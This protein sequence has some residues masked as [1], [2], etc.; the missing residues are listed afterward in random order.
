MASSCAREQVIAARRRFGPHLAPH[1]LRVSLQLGLLHPLVFQLQRVA[2]LLRLELLG[3]QAFHAAL[4]VGRQVH[5]ADQHALEQHAVGG[6]A[7][8]QLGLQ[9]LLD[10][11]AL[12]GEDLAHRVAREHLV[13]HVL[14]RRLHD[15]RV[16]A[17]RQRARRRRDA[18]GIERIAHGEV[19]ADGEPFD[20]LHRRGPGGARDLCRPVDAIAQ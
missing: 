3:Q 8:A 6:Q 11:G 9:R 1:L 12:G 10:F 7:R 14:H 5:L 18:R 13:D 15:L 20:G 2:H 17:G 16:Q 19:D 4:V